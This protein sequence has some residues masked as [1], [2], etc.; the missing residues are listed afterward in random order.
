MSKN[1]RLKKCD[2]YV[3]SSEIHLNVKRTFI[4]DDAVCLAYN[5]NCC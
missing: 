2:P 1:V 4:A 3:F 5:G